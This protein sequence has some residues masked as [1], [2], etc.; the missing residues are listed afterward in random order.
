[1]AIVDHEVE[2]QSLMKL[3]GLELP[4]QGAA[5]HQASSVNELGLGFIR[6]ALLATHEA[7]SEAIGPLKTDKLIH[8]CL[9]SVQDDKKFT[10]SEIANWLE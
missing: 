5:S 4:P 3:L 10:K 9:Q 2:K 1:M 8:E 7:V 6:Q